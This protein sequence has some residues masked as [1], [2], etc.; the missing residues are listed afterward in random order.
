MQR[1]CCSICTTAVE[2][3]WA[4]AKTKG[5]E[6]SPFGRVAMLMAHTGDE[7]IHNQ[8]GLLLKKV[9]RRDIFPFLS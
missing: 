2:F 6:R 1:A 8:A 7:H 3:R 9:R 5:H 4:F